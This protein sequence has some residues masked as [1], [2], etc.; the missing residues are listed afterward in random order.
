VHPLAESVGALAALVV[1]LVS[2]LHGSSP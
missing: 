2:A 1:G